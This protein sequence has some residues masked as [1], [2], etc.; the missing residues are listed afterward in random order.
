MN[1][2][3][4]MA[5]S[6]VFMAISGVI[7]SFLPHE[8][9][10]FAN[11]PVSEFTALIFQLTGALYLGFAMLNWSAKNNLIGGIYSRPLAFGNFLHFVA[12]G[13]ALLKGAMTN[14]QT[15]IWAL[16]VV[17]LVFAALFGFVTFTHPKA[18]N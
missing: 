3:V 5:A 9:L 4:L 1:T 8:I 16:A 6:A 13:L 14:G 18:A 2:R 15:E 12:G 11:A 17:Y 7:F 10:A